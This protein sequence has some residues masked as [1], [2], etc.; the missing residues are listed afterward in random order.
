LVSASR[1]RER[2]LE[3]RERGR[4]ILEPFQWTDPRA[5]RN[6]EPFA[7]DDRLIDDPAEDRIAACC[8]PAG[9]RLGP[10]LW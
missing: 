3:R 6:R 1:C 2:L 8:K 4:T 10:A 5:V 9:S 7:G